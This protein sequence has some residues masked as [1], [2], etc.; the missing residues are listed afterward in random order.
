MKDTD[1]K[2]VLEQQHNLLGSGRHP[3]VMYNI[4]L[5]ESGGRHPSLSILSETRKM[6]QMRNQKGIINKD[7][8]KPAES[9]QTLTTSQNFFSLKEILKLL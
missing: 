4:L 5:E 1:N 6:K 7:D 3:N 9:I 2:A 8:K